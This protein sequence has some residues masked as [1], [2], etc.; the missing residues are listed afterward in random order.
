MKYV[1][2]PES[3]GNGKFSIIAADAHEALQLARILLERGNP[4]IEV[5][6][7]HDTRYEL[8]DLERL[9]AEPA[10]AQPL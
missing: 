6:D 9:A 5:L 8:A 7:E 2:R 3:N 4:V 10:P 1:V